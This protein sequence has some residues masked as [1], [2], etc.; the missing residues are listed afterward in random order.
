MQS[1]AKFIFGFYVPGKTHNLS[2]CVSSDKLSTCTQYP[3]TFHFIGSCWNIRRLWCTAQKIYNR[4]N[5]G[6]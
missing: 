3:N 4:M 1:I 2:V 5:T 6:I